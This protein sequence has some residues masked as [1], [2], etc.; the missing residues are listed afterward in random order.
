MTLEDLIVRN[1]SYRRFNESHRLGAGTLRDLVNVARRTPSAANRR[2]LKDVLMHEPEA[3]A[4]LFPHLAWAGALTDWPGP[5]EGERPAAYLIVL[6]DT[7]I[8]PHA[9]CDH[10]IACQ[11][12][13]LAAVERGLGGC[14]V[15]AI[16][17]DAIRRNFRIPEACEILLVVALGQPA[18]TCVLEEAGAG[19]DTTYWRDAAGVHACAQAVAERGYSRPVGCRKREMVAYMDS[20][21]RIHGA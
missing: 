9:D 3:C 21:A 14:R 5:A 19:G 6:C 15:G 17:R 2:P 20:I 18:E 12:M 8:H 7:A 13:L 1:R 10:G 4:R 11:S 16:D